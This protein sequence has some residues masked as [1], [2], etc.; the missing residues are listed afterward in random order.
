MN[1]ESLTLGGAADDTAPHLSF[2]I[3]YGR[4]LRAYIEEGSGFLVV[5][6]DEQEAHTLRKFV[7]QGLY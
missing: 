1:F 3:A 2:I 5:T 4:D 6:K 7:A